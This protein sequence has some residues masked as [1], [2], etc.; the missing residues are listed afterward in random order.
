[1][2]RTINVEI[3]NYTIYMIINKDKTIRYI[4][5]TSKPLEER[6]KKH[7]Y[8]CAAGKGGVLYPYFRAHGVENFEIIMIEQL[9]GV[10]K[11][12]AE[13]RETFFMTQVVCINER[14]SYVDE[15]EQRE[16]IVK[17]Q[18]E[19]YH[20]N[21]DRL[22][23]QK[24]EYREANRERLNEQQRVRG[25]EHIQCICGSTFRCDSKSAHLRTQIHQQR[26]QEQQS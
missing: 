25:A 2:Q 19:R 7:R 15:E 10:T 22:L 6:F 16:Q 12:E 24:R 18:S 21:R 17:K 3:S 8:A 1:M 4:G 9:T 23:E 13:A 20:A 14:R 11:R 26:M 5:M